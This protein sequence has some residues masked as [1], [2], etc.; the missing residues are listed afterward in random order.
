MTTK[1][2]LQEK[3]PVEK[4]QIPKENHELASQAEYLKL[5][6][7]IPTQSRCIQ[8]LK[9]EDIQVLNKMLGGQA[10][11]FDDLTIKINKVTI[12]RGMWVLFNIDGSFKTVMNP[13]K[14][15]VEFK[16]VKS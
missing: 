14:F 13:E 2:K 10:K 12:K 9:I 3:Q 4:V 6:E 8:Y 15:D 16:A 1:N 7:T 11:I 5:F